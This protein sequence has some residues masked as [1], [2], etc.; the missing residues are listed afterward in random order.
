MFHL[1]QSAINFIFAEDYVKTT[2]K[3]RF[4]SASRKFML[5]DSID[6]AAPGNS[7]VAHG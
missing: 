6:E 3:E 7:F 2:L 1:A 5:Q 4:D